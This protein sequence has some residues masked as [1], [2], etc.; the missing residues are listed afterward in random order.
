ML[1]AHGLQDLRHD[2]FHHLQH[3]IAPHVAHLDVHL[4]E[5]GLTV[6]T[7]V[8]VAEAARDLVVALHAGAHEHLLELL[9]ALGQR[10]ELAGIRTAGDDVV[11]GSLRRGVGQN[12]RLHLKESAFV[13]RGAHGLRKGMTQQQALVHFRTT[14]VHVAPFHACDLVGFDAVF[15]AEG[16]GDAG[17]QNLQPAGQ[18]LDLAGEH[19][20]VDAFFSTRPHAA[21]HFQHVLA[22]QMLGRMELVLGHAIRVYHDLGVAGAVAQIDEDEP[23][24]VAVM[25][26]P[27]RQHDLAVDIFLAQFAAGGGVHA[28]LVQKVRHVS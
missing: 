16:R 12:G 6:G 24:V 19:A 21:S 17:V 28:V 10:V 11:A 23:A 27:A 2:V 5:L 22:A 4:G 13:Q 9:R 25:P 26:Y 1:H 18:H 7:Q 8:L 14:Q 3:V 20:G 15:D